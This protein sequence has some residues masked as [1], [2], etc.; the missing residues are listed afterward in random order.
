MK[1]FEVTIEG[2]TPLKQY[3]PVGKDLEKEM[4]HRQRDEVAEVHCYRDDKGMIYAPSRWFKGCIRDYLV[5][6]SGKGSK[7]T[8]ERE[9]SS[10][11]LAEPPECPLRPQ[12]YEIDVTN[13]L[14]KK[15][16]KIATMTTCVRPMFRPPWEIDFIVTFDLGKDAKEYK[17]IIDGAGRAQGIGSN[18]KNGYG[19]FRVKT[20]NE[21]EV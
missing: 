19:R 12:Q 11:V 16:G 17:K 7:Q 8:T 21:I 4:E 15:N 1:K 6:V 13:V 3:R 9:A 14:V 10:Y 20:F 18:T 2:I 5:S